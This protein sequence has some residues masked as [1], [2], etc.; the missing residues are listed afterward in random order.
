[1]LSV[2]DKWLEASKSNER[3][4]HRHHL[5]LPWTFHHN[6][7]FPLILPFPLRV[8]WSTYL[9]F[10]QSFLSSQSFVFTWS[11]LLHSLICSALALQNALDVNEFFRSVG[12]GGKWGS[13]ASGCYYFSFCT[14]S[15]LSA[16]SL[17]FLGPSKRLHS[18]NL[19]ALIRE[20]LHRPKG[21]SVS[22]YFFAWGN[23]D[24]AWIKMSESVCI[25]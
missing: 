21:G 13:L 2:C 15:A 18:H 10:Y 5:S 17:W 4:I 24:V 14:V 20:S 8:Q 19:K 23:V 6:F 1:M 16:A 25:V 3:K 12:S 9:S 11:S 7:S 22:V